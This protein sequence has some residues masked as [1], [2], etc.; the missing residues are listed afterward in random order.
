MNRISKIFLVLISM[1]EM[2]PAD[3]ATVWF[4]TRGDSGIHRA[5]L[6]LET[7]KLSEPECAFKMLNCGFLALHPNEH[8]LYSLGRASTA[9]T[10]DTNLAAFDIREDNS[11]SLINAVNSN[12][13][14][15]THLSVTHDGSTLL[16][17]HYSGGGVASLP[18]DASG[19]IQAPTTNV[20][21]AG[22]SVDRRRQ[23]KP[24]P[25][26]IG[27]TPDNKFAFVPDLGTDNVVIY[28]LNTSDHTLTPHGS[29]EVP[30]GAGPRHLT[31]HPT[32]PWV[33]V[34]NE[35]DLT[36]TAFSYDASAGML[37]EIET[38][39][40]LPASEVKDVLTSGSEIRMHPNGRYLYAGIRGHDVIAVFEIGSDGKPTLIE[41]EPIRGSWPR[42]FALDPTGRWLLAAGAESD[43]VSVFKVD[44]DSGKLTFTRQIVRV[45]QC[46]CVT[47]SR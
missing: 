16:V 29:A 38:V 41:R 2:L 33:Y 22:S 18:I 40:A 3:D 45:P 5:T 23:D 19:A 27:A 8:R 24:H 26:W 21:H 10:S 7:G 25:H 28:K 39:V 15:P 31:F 17:A 1:T 43:T 13:G 35:L 12:G 42:N 34:I 9:A 6:N 11:L 36:V 20:Q 37:T 14:N 47:F 44:A 30:D 4:G 32:Q 46:I